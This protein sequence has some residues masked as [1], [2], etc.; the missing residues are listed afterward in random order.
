METENTDASLPEDA[1]PDIGQDKLEPQPAD[2]PTDSSFPRQAES[3]NSIKNADLPWQVVQ[4]AESLPQEVVLI[5]YFLIGADHVL[6]TNR[7]F[8]GLHEG[9]LNGLKVFTVVDN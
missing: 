3:Y 2:T 9:S 8:Y 1:A 7:G 6:I 4:L 5:A